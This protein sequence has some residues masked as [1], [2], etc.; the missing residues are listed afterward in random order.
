MNLSGANALVTGAN[1]GLGA[2]L[3]EELLARGAGTVYAAA[4][5]PRSV[6]HADPRVVPLRLDV[7]DLA[8]I[9]DAA[10]R[11][12][13]VD[14]LI[15]N[16][17]LSGAGSLLTGDPE[18][19]RAEMETNY[20]GPV[21]MVR[22]FA[23]VL[24]RRGGGTVVTVLSALSWAAAPWAG[25]YAATKAAA[26]SFTNGV[27]VELREQGTHVVGVHLGFMDT[28]MVAHLD[29]PKIT[30]SSVAAQIVDGVEA[31]AEEVLADAPS[32]GLKQALAGSPAGLEV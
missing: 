2:A 27:R 7:T 18:H 11:A 5:D 9:R 29:V 1:R 19:A 30:A 20:W 31:G 24:A 28:D 16:A 4:R 25:S 3:V 23:P 32:R 8:T 12:G 10:A 6:V 17:G 26:W 15:N 14:L 22:A 21:A 13:D